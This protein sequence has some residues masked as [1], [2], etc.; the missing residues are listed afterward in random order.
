MAELKP[1]P[2][3]GG[4]A[5]VLFKDHRFI[6]Y[7]GLGDKKVSYRVQV[8]CNKCRSRGKPVITGGLINPNPYSSVWGNSYFATSDYC[9]KQTNLF[10]EFVEAAIAAWNSRVGEEG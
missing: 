2:F 9:K 7:N 10:A 5:K 4:K 1:C 6:G 8:I 3:C